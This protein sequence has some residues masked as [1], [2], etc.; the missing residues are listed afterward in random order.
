MMSKRSW[1]GDSGMLT[2]VMYRNAHCKLFNPN[3]RL[4]RHSLQ[5]GIFIAW[6]SGVGEIFF[7]PSIGRYIGI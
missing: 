4:F 7:H 6:S 1:I 5:A 3:D 2:E